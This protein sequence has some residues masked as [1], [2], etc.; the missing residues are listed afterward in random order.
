MAFS[1]NIYHK[2]EKLPGAL[3]RDRPSQK[4]QRY[5]HIRLGR[6][7]HVN[8]DRYE[9]TVEWL[10]ENGARDNVPLSFAYMGP[11]GII[12]AFPEEYSI[13]IF[14][15]AETGGTPKPYLLSMVPSG[16]L[17]AMAHDLVQ[18]MPDAIPT[19]DLNQIQY[20]HR[21]MFPGDMQMTS[22]VGG[23]LFINHNVEL[24]N[25][26]KDA[27]LIRSG[28][29]AIIQTAIHN[30]QFA[31]GA[32]IALG[33]AVRNASNNLYNPDG[34]LIPGSFITPFTTKDMKDI[35]YVTTNGGTGKPP[36]L[37]TQYFT[38][39]RVD[40]DDVGNG[41]PDFNEINSEQASLRNPAVSMYL[42]NMIGADP[43][44]ISKY[45]RPLRPILFKSPSDTAGSFYL[46]TTKNQSGIDGPMI[47]GLA[48]ALQFKSSTFLG[49]DKEGHWHVNLA[50]S[51]ANPL[52]T[53]RSMSILAQGNLKEIWGP[54]GDSGNSWNLTAKGGVIWD[55]GAH[56]TTR[57]GTS[58]EINAAGSVS[59]T[60]GKNDAG[61]SKV[62]KF[63]GDVVTSIAGNQ[64]ITDNGMTLTVRGLKTE[65][66][67]GSVSSTFQS[68]YS[69]N[70]S[71]VKTVTVMKEMQEKFGKQ[72]KSITL[73]NYEMEVTLGDI[74]KSITG[75]GGYMVNLTAGDVAHD[76]KVGSIKNTVLTGSFKTSI[77]GVGG[78]EMKNSATSLAMSAV[79]MATLKGSM[80]SVIESPIVKLGN[81][82]PFGGAITG[83]PGIP[84]HQ[85]FITGAPLKGSTKVGIA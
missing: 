17:H 59:E 10:F 21:R 28:D 79:G 31:D 53:G 16:L 37:N 51:K 52:G 61:I 67:T 12:G 77:D 4:M 62:E 33:P 14:G 83:M 76:V 11:A 35:F 27:I 85:D 15:F 75:V 6:I 7:L 32:S 54:D 19:E 3:D 38:E 29:R 78:I 23:G 70:V 64:I 25:D 8:P 36:D 20:S 13:G 30:Y 48:W 84:S 69:Q 50:A 55:L 45:A 74:K 56:N 34:T 26:Y 68:D 46:A 42:G 57:G 40:V 41:Q 81:G 49:V 71:G 44:D 24:F 1:S 80:Q 47:L 9:M 65:I 73:G 72:K 63:T 58:L 43:R 2:G 22:P 39:Y 66:V 82:A 18:I 60:Y 5:F